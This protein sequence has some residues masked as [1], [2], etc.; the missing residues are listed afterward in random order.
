MLQKVPKIFAITSLLF[1]VCVLIYSFNNNSAVDYLKVY[2]FQSSSSREE[3]NP[4]CCNDRG[5]YYCSQF[6]CV[7]PAVRPEPRI[8]A[9]VQCD[10]NVNCN[11]TYYSSSSS[12][13]P[14]K[15]DCCYKG[16]GYACT[17]AC[18]GTNDQVI[19]IGDKTCDT[20]TTCPPRSSSPSSSSR[21]T[22]SSLSSS[23]SRPIL[24][25][26][27]RSGMGHY[28]ATKCTPWT[29]EIPLADGV[30]C[31]PS[32]CHPSSSSS[33]LSSSSVHSSSSHSSSSSSS[34]H[35]SSSE[36]SSPSRFE[37]S[38]DRDLRW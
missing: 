3:L 26:C 1:V 31:N 24:N 2:M 28:C 5:I 18:N 29:T 12:S 35:S 9:G 15:P 20:A 19:D 33:R 38:S 4:G 7:P 36:S 25:V 16:G 21:T 13:T 14:P 23:T 8:P 30:E 32:T 10:R 6:D 11:R 37:R 17:T 34:V 27:C 22:S